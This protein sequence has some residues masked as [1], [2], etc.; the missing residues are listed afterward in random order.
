METWNAPNKAYGPDPSVDSVIVFASYG[1]T[2]VEVASEKGVPGED[3]EA[4]WTVCVAKVR[5]ELIISF[6]HAFQ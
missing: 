2:P 4:Q 3:G 5:N 1:I 6:H